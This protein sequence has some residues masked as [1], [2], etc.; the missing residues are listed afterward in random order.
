MASFIP[1]AAAFAFSWL[2]ADCSQ[3]GGC[4]HGALSL[5]TSGRM[6]QADVVEHT[7]FCDLW[8]ILPRPGL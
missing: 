4:C 1:P 6:N 8:G 5:Q 7:D 2:S 3:K